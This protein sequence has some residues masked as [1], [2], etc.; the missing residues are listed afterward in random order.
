MF[1]PLTSVALKSDRPTELEGLSISLRIPVMLR[2]LHPTYHWGK[3]AKGGK[4][5]GGDFSACR[6]PLQTNGPVKDRSVHHHD[7]S[8]TSLCCR[9]GP[10]QSAACTHCGP[11]ERCRADWG[12]GDEV[13]SPSPLRART[14]TLSE[15][16]FGA[17]LTPRLTRREKQDAPD[18]WCIYMSVE[19]SGAAFPQHVSAVW[20]AKAHDIKEKSRIRIGPS[21]F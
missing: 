1:S 12:A 18:S 19:N 4:K 17:V 3:S 7:T 15:R 10:V 20:K 8:F 13:L 16:I 2:I 6:A 21:F 9:C 11:V 5:A 14:H